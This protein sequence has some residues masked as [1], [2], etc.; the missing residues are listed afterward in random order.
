MNPAGPEQKLIEA[1]DCYVRTTRPRPGRIVDACLDLRT[2]V[3][4]L[5]QL[6]QDDP[7]TTQDTP[8]D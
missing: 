6:K 8:D 3:E 2:V 7:D 5:R 4:E 1:I